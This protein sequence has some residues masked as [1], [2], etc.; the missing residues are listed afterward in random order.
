[1]DAIPSISN[2]SQVSSDFWPLLKGLLAFSF[3]YYFFLI[4]G[5]KL[6]IFSKEASI[7]LTALALVS[8]AIACVIGFSRLRLPRTVYLTLGFFAVFLV[9]KT[10]SP[11]VNRSAAIN[12]VGSISGAVIFFTTASSQ[13]P[14]LNLSNCII[15][16][17]NQNFLKLTDSLE[18][19][20][21][22]A[23]SVILLLCL[24]QLCVASGIGLWIGNGIDEVSHLIPVA[25][26]ATLADS[27]SVAGGATAI[28]IKS[29]QIHY[30]LLRFPSLGGQQSEIP[31]LIGLTDFLFFG[32]FY[33]A[34]F[35][36]NLGVGKNI[37]LLFSS[38]VCAVGSAVILKAG[39][40]VLP[41]M[42]VLFV[43]GNYSNLSIKKEDKKIMAA[44]FVVMV[45]GA[46]LFSRFMSR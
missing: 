10:A 13:N 43:A 26:I 35:R 14:G 42:A 34:A 40:P 37:I 1:M 44:F 32:I 17:R 19:E 41:F 8:F 16:T 5:A 27:W 4:F 22:E 12:K 33:Q 25:F 15:D 7:F 3:G 45:I 36:F 2:S 9:L 20:F 11:L 30:F 46:L 29:E 23:P 28:I 6:P 39:L 38:F 24:L 31:F 18:K 21:P